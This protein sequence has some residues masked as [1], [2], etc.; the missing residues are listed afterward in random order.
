MSSL[1]VTRCEEY[2]LCMDHNRIHD[3]AV[4]N[5]TP[6]FIGPDS[7]F[8]GHENTSECFLRTDSR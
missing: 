5:G 1:A 4:M 2:S 7:L 6:I 3:V 8:H